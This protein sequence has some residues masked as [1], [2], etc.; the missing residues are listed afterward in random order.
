MPRQTIYGFA[1]QESF[2]RTR[3]ATRRVLGERKYGAQR[4]RQSPV[5]GNVPFTGVLNE[6]INGQ[7]TGS[8]STTD[9]ALGVKVDTGKDV[10]AFNLLDETAFSGSRCWLI[11]MAGGLAFLPMQLS[12]IRLGKTDSAI[13][14]DSNGTVSR[15]SGTPNSE[16]DTTKNDLVYNW[17]GNVASGKRVIY[18][19]NGDGYYIIGAEC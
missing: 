5:L 17:L 2:N 15:W 11:R 12:P 10:D 19:W 6:D 9:G 16:I 4:R 18:A 13:A 1:D 3:T 14:K 7:A 8:V